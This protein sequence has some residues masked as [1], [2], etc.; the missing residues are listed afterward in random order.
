MFGTI[1]TIGEHTAPQ[2]YGRILDIVDADVDVMTD[3]AIEG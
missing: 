3:C 1:G 2:Y